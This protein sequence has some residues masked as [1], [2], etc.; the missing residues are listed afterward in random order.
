MSFLCKADKSKTGSIVQKVASGQFF[1]HATRLGD[2]KRRPRIG[3]EHIR[4]Y[5]RASN[6]SQSTDFTDFF[7]GALVTAGQCREH[8]V[9]QFP[10]HRSRTTRPQCVPA[11]N[12]AVFSSQTRRSNHTEAVTHDTFDKAKLLSLVDHYEFSYSPTEEFQQLYEI[13]PGPSL[14][15][16]DNP[17]DVEWPP[18]EHQWLPEEGEERETI[19]EIT[20]ALRRSNADPDRVYQLY[21]SL[22]PPR[23]TYLSWIIR[24]RFLRCL[25]LV[26]KKDEQ[27]MLRYLSVLDDM[28]LNAV[29]ATKAE[30][31]TAVSF[32]ANYMAK[33]TDVEVEAALRMFKDME[34]NAGLEA[35]SATFNILFDA[36]AKAGKWN[37]AEMIHKEMLKRELPFNRF[38]HVSHMF[39]HGLRGDGDMV[40]QC[41]KNLVEAGEL[42]DTVVL[43]CVIASL[44][45]AGEPQAALQVYERMKRLH[46]EMKVPRLPPK[47]FLENRALRR[48]LRRLAQK[49]QDDEEGL[50]ATQRT[51]PVAP[52]TR[53]YQTLIAYFAVQA[54]D[55]TTVARLLN[56]MVVYE[57]PIHGTIFMSLFRGFAAHGG[58]LYSQWRLPYLESIWETFW[59]LQDDGG[60]SKVYLGKYVAIHA[61]K[62]FYKCSGSARTRE[63]WEQISSDWESK[64]EDMDHVRNVLNTLLRE[65]NPQIEQNDDAHV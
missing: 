64:P 1:A 27:S 57:A 25:G 52:D 22:P 61:L 54:G 20:K 6:V 34:Q 55:M 11:R 21:R 14:I 60:N 26:E 58:E 4:Q 28:K 65:E 62:A 12:N 41:Y 45:R 29:P 24:H 33:V 46:S 13:S 51:V 50:K 35:N 39:Y 3:P 17:N 32:V 2:L 53:T 40:R 44:L 59:S 19:A 31:N 47:T 42:V 16:S 23:I 10:S 7:I 18:R 15:V 63:V 38:H 43:N 48:V 56:E 36:A 49:L 8:R 37:L 5:G 30:W 9:S